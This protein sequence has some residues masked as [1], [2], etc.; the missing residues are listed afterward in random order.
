MKKDDFE[1]VLK[2]TV[3]G[4]WD[5]VIAAMKRF[6][7]F[8]K[9]DE[10]A[11][12]ECCIRSKLKTF[13]LDQTILGDGCGYHNYTYFV[14]K[15]HCVLIEHLYVKTITKN[16]KKAYVLVEKIPAKYNKESRS[17]LLTG[18]KLSKGD[19]KNVSIR[20]EGSANKSQKSIE[21]FCLTIFN[22]LMVIN[23]L[24]LDLILRL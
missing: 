10:V 18:A 12:R 8:D 15:G 1:I 16:G 3:M 6:R 13:N 21:R 20:D 22:R 11:Q 24:V 23:L 2:D 19:K 17:T 5:K 9:W 7:Y 14:L 4:E